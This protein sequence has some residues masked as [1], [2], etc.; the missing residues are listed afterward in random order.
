MRKDKKKSSNNNLSVIDKTLLSDTDNLKVRMMKAKTQIPERSY[1]PLY[2]IYYGKQT[3]EQR[4]KIRNCFNLREA[5]ETIT[6]NIEKMIPFLEDRK[7]KLNIG[8]SMAFSI[9]ETAVKNKKK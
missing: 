7:K 4:L 5:D 8:A 9:N 1:V 6:E 3:P 2:E